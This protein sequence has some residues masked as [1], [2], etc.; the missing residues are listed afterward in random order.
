MQLTASRMVGWTVVSFGVMFFLFG[1]LAATHILVR[2]AIPQSARTAAC[3][4]ACNPPGCTWA[5]PST[6]ATRHAAQTLQS[7]TTK[8]RLMHTLQLLML[9]T[10]ITVAHELLILVF[11]VPFVPVFNVHSLFGA[12][13]ADTAD[14]FTKPVTLPL[15]VLAL[16]LVRLK[17]FNASSDLSQ[18]FAM[19]VFGATAL[20]GVSQAM[21]LTMGSAWISTIMPVEFLGVFVEPLALASMLF[22]TNRLASHHPVVRMATVL[23]VAGVALHIPATMLFLNV[24]DITPETAEGIHATAYLLSSGRHALTSFVLPMVLFVGDLGVNQLEGQVASQTTRNQLQMRFFRWLMHEQR[25]PL[26][27]ISIAMSLAQDAVQEVHTIVKDYTCADASG[28]CVTGSSSPTA[29]SPKGGPAP[30]E[31]MGR[32]SILALLSSSEESLRASFSGVRRLQ[33]VMHQVRDFGA[34][35]LTD[36]G[37]QQNVLAFELHDM[38]KRVSEQFAPLSSRKGQHLMWRPLTVDPAMV[39]TGFASALPSVQDKSGHPTAAVWVSADIVRLRNAIHTIVANALK[40]SGKGDK[41]WVGSHVTLE[42]RGQQRERLCKGVD[43]VRDLTLN[44]KKGTCCKKEVVCA[45]AEE[46]WAKLSEGVGLSDVTLSSV[47]GSTSSAGKQYA[48]WTT[49]VEDSGRGI[50]PELQTQMWNPFA[51]LVPHEGEQNQGG[52]GLSL[53]IARA[54]VQRHGGSLH[55]FSDGHGHGTRVVMQVSLPVHMG[56]PDDALVGTPSTM[57]A[58][59]AQWAGPSTTSEPETSSVVSSATS[60]STAEGEDLPSAGH[61]QSSRSLGS[62]SNPARQDTGGSQPSHDDGTETLLQQLGGVGKAAAEESSAGQASPPKAAED[63][64]AT[65]DGVASMPDVPEEPDPTPS[66]PGA[67]PAAAGAASVTDDATLPPALPDANVTIPLRILVVDDAKTTRS[68]FKRLL[69]RRT[70]AEVIDTAENGKV[71]VDAVAA[72]GPAY[73]SLILMDKEMPIMDG[74]EAAAA[75][76]QLGYSRLMLGVTGNALLADVAEFKRKGVCRVLTKPVDAAV[77]AQWAD[78]STRYLGN[79]A[80]TP[81][82]ASQA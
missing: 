72:K 48:L 55:V 81:S 74:Y 64:V 8:L 9:S 62:G 68:L 71:A 22:F 47:F 27:D 11:A 25:S 21:L 36:T 37:F 43:A 70:K 24:Q 51:T 49:I 77:L 57:D 17:H 33:R 78:A 59:I 61:S 52:S 60:N 66:G 16:G 39:A 75:I 30:D 3:Q 53:I 58:E 6:A 10:A 4:P 40:F 44:L 67:G 31:P 26:N 46:V 76:R 79:D 23:F 12:V 73:Y 35:V 34:L 7:T 28:S 69:K 56:R 15:L 1:A 54:V 13:G 29:A 45:Q 14:N 20:L 5:P 65:P 2:A 82:A 38:L 32:E 63:G 80:P 19:A 18:R 50:S 42:T 41:I